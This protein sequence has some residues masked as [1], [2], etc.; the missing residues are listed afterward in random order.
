MF[1]CILIGIF[2]I[3]ILVLLVSVKVRWEKHGP[4][5]PSYGE[6]RKRKLANAVFIPVLIFSSIILIVFFL[7][8]F[9]VLNNKI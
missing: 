1:W 4:G 2:F 5:R 6:K 8:L 7:L 9:G 3:S